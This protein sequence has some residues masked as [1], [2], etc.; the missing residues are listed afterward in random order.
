MKKWFLLSFLISFAIISKAQIS[1]TH[2]REGRSLILT[3][4][5]GDRLRLTPYGNY[6]IRVQTVRK[7]EEFFPDDRYEMVESHQ[8][9][10]KLI[11]N[12]RETFFKISTENLREKAS[13]PVE[14]PRES[15][16]Q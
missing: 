8:W 5:Q 6:I 3:N 1:L 11:L 14:I 13:L 16:D 4:P 2:I 10:G 12:E 15:P 9:P 7:N